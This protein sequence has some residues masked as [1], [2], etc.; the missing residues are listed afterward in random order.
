MVGGRSGRSDREDLMLREDTGQ[1]TAAREI[2]T[3]LFGQNHGAC[4]ALTHFRKQGDG[5]LGVP[6][7]RARRR[8]RHPCGHDPAAVRGYARV[9][10]GGQLITGAPPGRCLRCL[11]PISEHNRVSDGWGET[12]A[13][14]R[15]V[16]L[17]VSE[18]LAGA[19]GVVYA[20]PRKGL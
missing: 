1:R 4:A 3:N 17:M 19:A 14:L 2:G 7:A 9:P 18:A 8:T 6:E 12:N 5:V 10:P 15:H 13:A 20:V 16:A 11:E